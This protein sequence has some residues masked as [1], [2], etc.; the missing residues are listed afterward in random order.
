LLWIGRS[1][2]SGPQPC[3]TVPR[4]V[5]HPLAV[6]RSARDYG[7][8]SNAHLNHSLEALLAQTIPSFLEASFVLR[9][10][11]L[12]RVKRPVRGGVCYVMVIKA[13]RSRPTL[14]VIYVVARQMPFAAHGSCISIGAQ[15]FGD[16]H[17]SFVDRA[18]ISI[19]T[20]N[21]RATISPTPTWWGCSPVSKEAREGQQRAVL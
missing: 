2:P 9:N 13:P 7:P 5:G 12:T 1:V 19:A 20:L 4:H 3:N 11:L 10:I 21:P 17:T 15:R 6:L 8:A 18:F 14:V 16:C